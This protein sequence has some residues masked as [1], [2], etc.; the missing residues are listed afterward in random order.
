MHG[1]LVVMNGREVIRNPQSSISNVGMVNMSG[2]GTIPFLSSKASGVTIAGL[3]LISGAIGIY[4]KSMW[5]VL[6]LILG[7]ILV[8]AGV[9]EVAKP[10]D[11]SGDVVL[12]HIFDKFT[13]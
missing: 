4:M 2:T 6:V 10:F 11:L 3:G 8:V 12:P 1:E 9:L 13:N 5:G 7:A